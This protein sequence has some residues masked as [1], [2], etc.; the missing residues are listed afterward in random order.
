MSYGAVRWFNRKIG[1]GFIRTDDGENVSFLNSAIQESHL[2]SIHKDT[3]VCL[4]VLKSQW[5]LTAINIRAA[6][7]PDGHE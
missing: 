1:A 7:T 6:E 4:E 5:G 2:C 3:R